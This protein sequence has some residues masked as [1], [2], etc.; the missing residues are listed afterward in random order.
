MK[1]RSCINGIPIKSSDIQDSGRVKVDVPVKDWPEINGLTLRDGE[2]TKEEVLRAVGLVRAGVGH[3][4][5]PA[6]WLDNENAVEIHMSGIGRGM[7][8]SP[9]GDAKEGCA[10][11]YISQEAKRVSMEIAQAM[12]STL[13]AKSSG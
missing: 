12:G 13:S 5:L 9:H 4:L 7:E 8:F 11:F 3:V 1:R 10:S 6:L 2:C